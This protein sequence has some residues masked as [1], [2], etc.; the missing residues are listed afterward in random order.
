MEKPGGC[1]GILVTKYKRETAEQSV[2]LWSNFPGSSLTRASQAGLRRKKRVGGTKRFDRTRV[3][4][5]GKGEGFSRGGWRKR[6][7]RKRRGKIGR[8]CT[9]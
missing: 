2:G 3:L 8:E 1:D 4:N 5:L 7:C 6:G 9:G